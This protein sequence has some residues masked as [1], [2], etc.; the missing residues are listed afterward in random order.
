MLFSVKQV[1]Q[2]RCTDKIEQEGAREQEQEQ[3]VLIK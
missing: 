2:E 3:E 1:V